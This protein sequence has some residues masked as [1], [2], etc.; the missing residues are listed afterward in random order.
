MYYIKQGMIM[1][2]NCNKAINLAINNANDRG[3]KESII[4][5]TRVMP[6]CPECGADMRPEAKKDPGP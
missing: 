5:Y 2:S 6:I 3:R 4:W 1:C